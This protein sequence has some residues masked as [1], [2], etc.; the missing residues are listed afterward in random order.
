MERNY[1]SGVNSLDFDVNFHILIARS[2]HNVA[3][4]QLMQTLF[5][6]MRKFQQRVWR[7]IYFPKEDYHTAYDFHRQIFDAIRT[8]DGLLAQKL[9]VEHL[10]IAQERC[11][12]YL[13]QAHDH[14]AE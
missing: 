10:N 11:I 12:A 14:N 7:S 13:A 5:D 9:M 1:E 8:K 2:A 6:S 3:W 4:L